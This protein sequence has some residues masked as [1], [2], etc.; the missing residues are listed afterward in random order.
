M[1]DKPDLRNQFLKLAQG[2]LIPLDNDPFWCEFWT[3]PSDASDI[4]NLRD[5]QNI[6]DQNL[7]NFLTLVRRCCENIILEARSGVSHRKEL[8]NSVRLLT[9]LLPLVYE[10]PSYVSRI[11]ENLFWRSQYDFAFLTPRRRKKPLLLNHGVA[12]DSSGSLPKSIQFG[13]LLILSLVEL[14]FTDKFTVDGPNWRTLGEYILWQAGLG[15]NSNAT[16]LNY[17]Y[18]SNRSEILRLLLTLCSSP[19]YEKVTQVVSSGSRFLNV[20]LSDLPKPACLSLV[21]SCFNFMARNSKPLASGADGD[22][23][24]L[25]E[26]QMTCLMM[27]GQ[28]VALMISYPV[29]SETVSGRS[30]RGMNKTKLFFS[31]LNTQL[32]LMFLVSNLVD[33]MRTPLEP[34]NSESGA[35][36]YS[37]SPSPA[38]LSSIV[39][40]WELYQCNSFVR[41]LLAKRYL[42][43]AIT[44]LLFH[45]YSFHDVAQHAHS[46]K[47]ATYFLLAISTDKPLVELSIFQMTEGLLNLFPPEFQT[48]SPMSLRDFFIVYSCQLL[49]A[50]TPQSGG[51]ISRILESFREFLWFSF[52]EMLYNIVPVLNSDIKASSDVSLRLSNI[53]HEGGICYQACQSLNSLVSLFSNREFLRRSSKNAELL[54]LLIRAITVACCKNP[55]A[56]SCLLMGILENESM[57][58]SISSVLKFFDDEHLRNEIRVLERLQEEEESSVSMDS[59]VE[60][61]VSDSE[62]DTDQG[63]IISPV[64][65]AESPIVGSRNN[66]VISTNTIPNTQLAEDALLELAL[67]PNFPCGMSLKAQEKLP[68]DATLR[69]SWGGNDALQVICA[70]II[71]GLKQKL[72]SCW[73][74]RAELRFD[75]YYISKQI[76]LCKF[77]EVLKE[78]EHMI[79]YDA[80]PFTRSDCLKISW[81]D[82]SLGWYTSMLYWDIYNAYDLMRISIKQGISIMGSLSSSIS[83]LGRLAS[84]W[85]GNTGQPN[86]NPDALLQEYVKQ[87]LLQSNPWA[88]TL[89]KLYQNHAETGSFAPFGIKFGDNF[90]NS[91]V[92]KVSGLRTGSRTSVATTGLE[93]ISERP[94]ALKRASVSS[95]HSLN[96]LNRARSY[97]PRNSFST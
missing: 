9:K 33:I 4:Y 62:L 80:L 35:V 67:R 43:K 38:I 53:N 92:R 88:N 47:V 15:G 96:S 10:L 76:E 55:Q 82:L 70:I 61:M 24:V 34:H 42:Q 63:S 28:L 79:P 21:F 3:S 54:S 23:E 77:D 29:P 11:E 51:K 26:A 12:S 58:Q 5:L 41:G 94:K 44:A 97:T 78:H 72:D 16:K 75:K 95:I 57:Y 22:K 87:G 71:P 89:L 52:T 32:E 69:M 8:L 86:N 83:I 73:S 65:S 31:K 7:P 14:L 66:S 60:L 36:S 27:A 59:D 81:N 64:D 49:N 30:Q 91:L 6:R 19:M 25:S 93:E 2:R 90:T 50:I 37:E 18:V 85:V 13:T 74:N 45:V 40:L 1:D 56:S 17:R 39:L 68:V 20:L 46:C 48:R 84:S